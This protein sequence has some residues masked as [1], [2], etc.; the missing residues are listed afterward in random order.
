MLLHHLGR[1]GHQRAVGHRDT[2]LPHDV[3][4]FQLVQIL[5]L[6]QG[7]HDVELVDETQVSHRTVHDRRAGRVRGQQVQGDR[8]PV[9][10]FVKTQSVGRVDL[11]NGREAPN[12]NSWFVQHVHVSPSSLKILSHSNDFPPH[13]VG[14]GQGKVFIFP[15]DRMKP[16]LIAD[17][18][19]LAQHGRCLGMVTARHDDVVA[20]FPLDIRIHKNHFPFAEQW[21]HRVVFYFQCERPAA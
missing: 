13:A 18:R 5:S 4:C 12:G 21:L 17:R 11:S 8:H 2:R 1:V 20:G 16:S 19:D 10:I 3:L 15:V 14:R 6:I 9:T 7:P